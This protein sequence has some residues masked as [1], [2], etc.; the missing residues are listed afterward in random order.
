MQ[1]QSYT[2]DAFCEAERICRSHLYKMWSEGRGPRYYMVRAVRRIS[3]EAR[4][5]WQRSLEAP[6][7]TRQA[8]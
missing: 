2:I 1:D 5:E 4:L 6:A 3:A 8:S 7:L